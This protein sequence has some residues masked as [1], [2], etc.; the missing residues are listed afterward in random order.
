MTSQ[1]V[2]AT[3]RLLNHVELVYRPG[4]RKLVTKVFETLGCVVVETGG[5]FLVIQI[6]P[7]EQ[8]FLDNVLYASEVTPAQWEFERVLLEQTETDGKLAAAYR[9]FDALRSREPQRTT[10]FGI[11]LESVEALEQLLARI[12]SLPDP[13]LEGRL[14]LAAVFRPGDPGALSDSLI[15]AFVR[16]DVCAAGLIRLGQHIELQVEISTH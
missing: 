2:D 10:H 15:Q 13:E 4:E 7:G 3:G 1:L 8:S 14:Q 9:E 5:P 16:T 12:R 6:Q 11:R